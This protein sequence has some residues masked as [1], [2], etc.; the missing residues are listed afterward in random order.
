MMLKVH[1][2]IYRRDTGT[3]IVSCEPV[4]WHKP[5]DA[6]SLYILNSPH[7]LWLIILLIFK[8]KVML[9]IPH[10]E[11][12]SIHIYT[13]MRVNLTGV[14]VKMVHYSVLTIWTRVSA[15]KPLFNAWRVKPM[16]TREDHVFLIGFIVAHAN[17]AGFVLLWKVCFVVLTEL[18]ERK[19]IYELLGHWL[20]YIII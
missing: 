18:W 3:S 17:R 19:G 16:E 13:S 6:L 4:A 2:I 10:I 14:A 1:Y 5:L 7:F 20:Y 8:F 12:V 11:T 9:F 15:L